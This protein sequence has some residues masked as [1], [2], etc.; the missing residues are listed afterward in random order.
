MIKIK[1]ENYL[2]RYFISNQRNNGYLNNSIHLQL[3]DSC[4]EQFG[5]NGSRKLPKKLF[6]ISGKELV[7]V[8]K[9]EQDQEVWLSYDD[10]FKS[11]HSMFYYA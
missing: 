4:G 2:K 5:T 9:L 10:H 1:R 11:F 7:N 8:Y 3:L 6:D